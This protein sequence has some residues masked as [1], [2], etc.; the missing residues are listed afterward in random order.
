MKES[1]ATTADGSRLRLETSS[2][3]AV[4]RAYLECSRRYS[5]M[6]QHFDVT[7]AQY[8]VLGAIDGLGDD[9]MPRAIAQRL[10]VTA[11]NVSGVIR[12][13]EER[14]LIELNEH[15]S[16][17]RSFVCALTPAGRRLTQDARSAAAR[18]IRAQLEPFDNKSLKLV[19]ALMRDMYSHLLT[20]DPDS[21]ALP[22]NPSNFSSAPD[23]APAVT[24][25]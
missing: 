23:R 16:D 24:K 25:E 4:V 1:P 6:L 19:E 3:F 10:L 13:L 7:V 9:A 11:A 12:R 2:W 8:D 5:Q 22:N 18:F 21:L 14:G 17:G 20:L 15:P